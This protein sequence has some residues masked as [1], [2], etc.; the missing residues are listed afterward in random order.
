M[1]NS[2]SGKLIVVDV[3][4][5]EDNMKHT[6][7][8]K[9][10]DVSKHENAHFEFPTNKNKFF[11]D[12]N[13]TFDEEDYQKF[14]PLPTLV[15]PGG[16]KGFVTVVN[17]NDNICTVLG[18]E[19]EV[20]R[21]S[22]EFTK[23]NHN[24]G[25]FVSVLQVNSDDNEKF[26][27]DCNI[28]EVTIYRVP[29]EKLGMALK[30]EGGVDVTKNVS[31]IYIQ[32]L[33]EGTPAARAVCTIKPLQAGDEIL[34]IQGREVSELTR[35][36]C[37]TI[38]R[39]ATNSVKLMVNHHFPNEV[40]HKEKNVTP[41]TQNLD[42]NKINSKHIKPEKER[43]KGF[44]PSIPPRKVN[45]CSRIF[46]FVQNKQDCSEENSD[47]QVILANQPREDL[48]RSF[49]NMNNQASELSDIDN[50]VNPRDFTKNKHQIDEN[51]TVSDDIAG[52]WIFD[53]H[54]KINKS[55]TLC[56]SSK[57]TFGESTGNSIRENDEKKIHQN[58]N[59]QQ[60][61]FPFEK[62][63]RELDE[64]NL[65]ETSELSHDF[66]KYDF[67]CKKDL[68]ITENTPIDPPVSFQDKVRTG[69]EESKV[70]LQSSVVLTGSPKI[71]ETFNLSSEEKGQTRKNELYDLN[72]TLSECNKK[73]D[74]HNI[75]KGQNKLFQLTSST[76]R[77]ITDQNICINVTQDGNSISCIP[78]SYNDQ[79]IP[80]CTGQS[81][82]IQ[83]SDNLETKNRVMEEIKEL[84]SE[85]KIFTKPPVFP[86]KIKM[87]LTLGSSNVIKDKKSGD[88]KSFFEVVR[89]SF[90]FAF[91]HKIIFTP[92]ELES[93]VFPA[94]SKSS[95]QWCTN[96]LKTENGKCDLLSKIR[97]SEKVEM[98][99]NSTDVIRMLK[100]KD[101][102]ISEMKYSSNKSKK[103]EYQ[104]VEV[105][106]QDSVV[107]KKSARFQQAFSTT[108]V[109]GAHSKRYSSEVLDSFADT[110]NKN[111]QYRSDKMARKF[112]TSS[113]E[114]SSTVNSDGFRGFENY[115][116]EHHACV[117]TSDIGSY[118]DSWRSISSEIS[119]LSNGSNF[120]KLEVERS[121]IN[122]QNALQKSESIKS[123]HMTLQDEAEIKRYNTT[124]NDFSTKM[125]N[126]P[127]V[128]HNILAESPCVSFEV[129]A[130]VP[131]DE[132][133]N[134]NIYNENHKCL[135]DSQAPNSHFDNLESPGKSRTANFYVGKHESTDK[136][137]ITNVYCD[138]Q[139]PLKNSH[140][141]IQKSL[142]ETQATNFHVKNHESLKKIQTTSSHVD[143]QESLDK[144]QTIN[145]HIVKQIPNKLQITNVYFDK[146]K[147]LENFHVDIQ[148]SLKETQAT[149]SHVD[150][151]E[152]LEETQ[153]TNF[154]VD[155]QKSLEETQATNS[156]FDK[157]EPPEKSQ[158]TDFYD[159]NQ[160]SLDKPQTA[161]NHTDVHN[162][163]DKSNVIKENISNLYDMD[164][165]YVNGVKVNKLSDFDEAHVKNIQDDDELDFL[166]IAHV[167][168]AQNDILDTLEKP[169]AKNILDVLEEHQVLK[170]QRDK[171]NNLNQIYVENILV[172]K[173]GTFDK[174]CVKTL[175]VDQL[176]TLE[177]SYAK[178]VNKNERVFSTT[179][180]VNNVIAE[181]LDNANK[182]HVGNSNVEKLDKLN[183]SNVKNM[184][185]HRK[186]ILNEVQNFQNDKQDILGKSYVTSGNVNNLEDFDKLDL[187]NMK[188]S[189]VF[190]SSANKQDC[191][192][193][194]AVKN[195]DF[196]NTG[197]INM[198]CE[199]N[200][201][202]DN[203]DVLD[204]LQVLKFSVGK[205]DNWHKAHVKNVRVDKL[206][207]M[208]KPKNYNFDVT[209][210]ISSEEDIFINTELVLEESRNEN[211][212]ADTYV[213]LGQ[214]QTENFQTISNEASNKLRIENPFF[215]TN[216]GLDTLY[217]K[218]SNM[219][220][221]ND[222][223][224][225]YININGRTDKY[226]FERSRD[227]RDDYLDETEVGENHIAV[228]V[229]LGESLD[230][231]IVQDKQYDI[232]KDNFKKLPS[233]IMSEEYDILNEQNFRNFH[234][235]TQVILDY[236]CNGRSH[237]N[238]T[239]RINSSG[240]RSRHKDE[241]YK[242]KHY[243]YFTEEKSKFNVENKNEQS[244]TKSDEI[245]IYQ[246]YFEGQCKKMSSFGPGDQ[247]GN[248]HENNHFDSSSQNTKQF[249][250]LVRSPLLQ[251]NNRKQ[252]QET[253]TIKEAD[254]S[255]VE[256]IKKWEAIQNKIYGRKKHESVVVKEFQPS[257][258]LKHKEE[259]KMNKA[260]IAEAY[261]QNCYISH[262]VKK[263]EI[264]SFGTTS[265]CSDT[266]EPSP[267][268]INGEK[269]PSNNIDAHYHQ[270][271][272][273]LRHSSGSEDSGVFL[274]DVNGEA[275][276]VAE[277]NVHT[278]NVYFNS[279]LEN[280][281][282]PP[283][284]E[285]FNPADKI[286]CSATNNGELIN[287]PLGKNSV[288]NVSS[289]N[290]FTFA[291]PILNGS[292]DNNLVSENVEPPPLPASLPPKL[293]DVQ[294]K[295]GKSLLSCSTLENNLVLDSENINLCCNPL[296]EICNDQ[297]NYVTCLSSN[298]HKDIDADG[299]IVDQEQTSS[300]EA[301]PVLEPTLNEGW[302]KKIHGNK[303]KEE[304][305]SNENKIANSEME[306]L[307]SESK[308]T[309]SSDDNQSVLP[310]D[311]YQFKAK[312]LAERE[313]NVNSGIRPFHRGKD[314]AKD[315]YEDSLNTLSSAETGTRFSNET[316]N[317]TAETIANTD[318]NKF[319]DSVVDNQ[320]NNYTKMKGVIVS[321]ESNNTASVSN[322]RPTFTS[323]TT[324][325]LPKSDSGNPFSG[326]QQ[327]KYTSPFTR[328]GYYFNS[329]VAGK[330]VSIPP[331][332]SELPWKST[333][334]DIPKYSPAFK[335]LSLQT[336]GV[337]PISSISSNMCTA[338]LPVMY[339]SLSKLSSISGIDGSGVS[340]AEEKKINKTVLPATCDKMSLLDSKLLPI[341]ISNKTKILTDYQEESVQE[342]TEEIIIKKM[343]GSSED[344]T[345]VPEVSSPLIIVNVSPTPE[346]IKYEQE[347]KLK[348]IKNQFKQSCDY[349][350][351][352]TEE[353]TIKNA[354]LYDCSEE[355]TAVKVSDT[356]YESN[357]EK[358][359]IT[360]KPKTEVILN[361]LPGTSSQSVDKEI[362]QDSSSLVD[363]LSNIEGKFLAQPVCVSMTVP[364]GEVKEHDQMLA[365]NDSEQRT[366]VRKT[367]PKCHVTRNERSPII[368]LDNVN[369]S[370]SSSLNP[371]LTR[372]E[373][374][375]NET[376]E[377][378]FKPSILSQ[379][380]TV[381]KKIENGSTDSVKNFRALAEKWEKKTQENK[382]EVKLSLVSS[383]TRSLGKIEHL[384]NTVHKGNAKLPPSLIPKSR[385]HQSYI[386]RQSVP[387]N[388]VG[389]NSSSTVK[390]REKR[391]TG[392]RPTS[393]IEAK[394]K[395][396]IDNMWN[397]NFSYSS[398]FQRYNNVS[399]E[400]SLPKSYRNYDTNE[401]FT[402]SRESLDQLGQRN[403]PR[404]STSVSDIRKNFQNQAKSAQHSW[405]PK[406]SSRR[407]SEDGNFFS[408][409]KC[410]LSSFSTDS[411][412]G[413][414]GTN[415]PVH[416]GSQTSLSSS[417]YDRYD[418]VTSL[419]STTSLISLQ[420]LQQLINEA[421]QSLQDEVVP[422]V[423]DVT[424][425]VIHREI[426]GGS[427]G[428]TLAGGVDCEVKE[429]TVHK[430]IT[431]SLAD[432]DG[433]IKKG[434]RIISINGRCV[435]GMSHSVAVNLLKSPRKEVVLV[436]SR[437]R[438]DCRPARVLSI[439]KDVLY[440]EKNVSYT[441]GAKGMDE[442]KKLNSE[443]KSEDECVKK[444]EILKDGTGLGFSLEG[445]KDSPAGDK[446]LIVKKVFTG[447]AAAK[448]GILKAGDEILAI[449]DKTVVNMTRTEAW[450]FM[451]KLTDGPV[452]ITL[453]EIR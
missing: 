293:E 83:M 100:R 69:H 418:S 11:S 177:N 195:I 51:V 274:D 288:K 162:I 251:V 198:S 16:C 360:R 417:S 6:T 380:K 229:A 44:A 74:G 57:K 151:Q 289:S 440:K 270:Y 27:H 427:I 96:S 329:N 368:L 238:T 89:K 62:L 233:K 191:L 20:S 313:I 55:K 106:N 179:S 161:N 441:V 451:K 123:F 348:E 355:L 52:K 334:S 302:S 282:E 197:A 10:T 367:V 349:E 312:L 328:R 346:E 298:K 412:T 174:S 446:P 63:E 419:A 292:V 24:Q 194:A 1:F 431:G 173:L 342:N 7:I 351:K 201:N 242:S 211:S 232:I 311:K 133:Q 362:S 73:K 120:D 150:I 236:I 444:V 38:L 93:N 171:D 180:C 327:K 394:E 237:I 200:V 72:E 321:D 143:I 178:N 95:G 414:T 158:V 33:G 239:K 127:I 285:L 34:M 375:E 370:P 142:D 50:S 87:P 105:T 378:L 119:Q 379:Q 222:L 64:G 301:S 157:H 19:S 343:Y 396:H 345:S 8:S 314:L 132:T 202:F 338:P 364:G 437:E 58:F 137:Q 84:N 125:I 361:T 31:K 310:D 107:S 189:D 40:N 21:G 428:I 60:V 138:H 260:G 336:F 281:K 240:R 147:S 287:D 22:T 399:S 39:E 145:S 116:S 411:D 43:K 207:V 129:D 81:N 347:Y 269:F 166:G 322:L 371:Q 5:D 365:D 389:T 432:R 406:P 422:P 356:R 185:I 47:K 245:S 265:K 112:L 71:L 315:N 294:S 135:S 115:P 243:H 276:R 167:Y 323:S 259:K 68:E 397:N 206:D 190:N 109:S 385:E 218:T 268:A 384:P 413:G 70:S 257:R 203:M 91:Q 46:R 366:E 369:S 416:Y 181:N 128:K 391:S 131:L 102:S 352:K 439:E 435:K 390:L 141:D 216:D 228:D 452:L 94:V 184:N 256:N 453:R 152:S 130:H 169:C 118:K 372:L 376:D 386:R 442:V 146:E 404:A 266:L 272:V 415:T 223:N 159:N 199:K 358:T 398:Y 308:E 319:S 75:Y 9:K 244:V 330:D 316:V 423:Q 37:I 97:I 80:N 279:H 26:K 255:E 443:V 425:V 403:K 217:E 402:K 434:D 247:S 149:N 182:P 3:Y 300:S 148:E 2:Q 299:D 359:P 208:K 113:I 408:S 264:A 227:G 230:K 42:N 424:V 221:K 291:S 30:F 18:G 393:L 248:H 262:F 305:Y 172:D 353:D 170:L 168:N 111:T 45:K 277:K 235:D 252:K 59:L 209:K 383:S 420:E 82:V 15:K 54:T 48:R 409:Y 49:Q 154:H 196:D 333:D 278:D 90:P 325:I 433:R 387:S 214:L 275:G 41:L 103:A 445:G 450:N 317:F 304:R 220:V 318:S 215:V 92:N 186:N 17:V 29:D 226:H 429:I 139:K 56:S 382:Q 156:H 297:L 12:E 381:L 426:Q 28:E 110:L 335:C 79:E 280:S 192:A 374:L 401:A 13:E 253:L 400:E 77:E 357:K 332:L 66:L 344:I 36:D 99:Q 117:S 283:T 144:T 108:M 88:T 136:S 250:S 104:N 4:N 140:F 249:N 32:S 430:V 339:S 76:T 122:S 337:A 407:T 388:T 175:Q 126:Y 261:Q 163:L 98:Y 341:H 85:E 164:K 134:I 438:P 86:R 204:E 188:K 286:V 176:D 65:S 183:E 331:I 210:S 224:K 124:P 25:N 165:S 436:V 267:Q 326:L 303:P 246:Q 373:R 377:T 273:R 263:C 309:F 271:F 363:F 290:G 35:F 306:E 205:L 67:T 231:K 448:E 114:E 254:V 449:N 320:T 241:G 354:Y 78:K 234:V 212:F 219:A 225:S 193:K 121:D 405:I 410:S 258:A 350:E 160:A 14:V 395:V 23:D 307:C 392:P 324:N 421:N 101:G 155:I 153:V 340:D 61:L 295:D 447:G 296:S 284:S 53:K 213:S 187:K